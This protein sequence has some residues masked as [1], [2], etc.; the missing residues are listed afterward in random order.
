MAGWHDAAPLPPRP[1]RLA[2]RSLTRGGRIAERGGASSCCRAAACHLSPTGCIVLH[3]RP[4]NDS[5][6]GSPVQGA[7]Q[8]AMGSCQNEPSE[9]RRSAGRESPGGCGPSVFLGLLIGLRPQWPY[10]WWIVP[11]AARCGDIPATRSSP[12]A[13]PYWGTRSARLGPVSSQATVLLHP[14]LQ[15]IAHHR[16]RRIPIQRQAVHA[17]GGF[18]AAR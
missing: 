3:H 7:D 10:R 13:C 14:E 9:D 4:A 5:V 8:K 17:Y 12:A 2:T 11:A 16:E 15:R 6:E 1:N 18:V